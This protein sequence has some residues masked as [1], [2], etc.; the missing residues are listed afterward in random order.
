MSDLLKNFVEPPAINTPGYYWLINSE[1]SPDYLRKTVAEFAAKGAKVIYPHP[2]PVKFRA[3]I[4]STMAPDYLTEEYFQCYGIILDECRKHGLKL[5]LYDEGGWPSGGACGKVWASDPAKFTRQ[6]IVSNGPGKV[7]VEYE[8]I[9]PQRAPLPDMLHPDAVKKFIEFTHEEY[10]RRFPDDFGTVIKFA[11]MDE[12]GYIPGTLTRIP[13]C[14]DFAEEFTARKNYDILPYLPDILALHM[15]PA[16]VRARLDYYDVLSR[17]FTERFT[18]PLQK[19]CREHGLISGGHMDGEDEPARNV[20]QTYGQIMRTLRTLD[21]PGVDLIWRQ[22][23][24]GDRLHTFPKF[25]SSVAHQCGNQYVIGE[26]FSIYGAGLTFQQMRFLVAYVIVCGVNTLAA[27]SLPSSTRGQRIEGLRPFFGAVNPA[28]QYS[29]GFHKWASRL[30][31]L[32]AN[33]T[34]KVENALFY[35]TRSLQILPRLAGYASERQEHIAQRLREQQCDFDYIDDDVL[36]EAVIDPAGIRVGQAVYKRIILPPNALMSEAAQQRLEFLR[37]CGAEIIS[38]DE[39]YLVKPLLDIPQTNFN[40]ILRTHERSDGTL[41]H[42]ILNISQLPQNFGCAL[43]DKKTVIA[44]PETGCFQKLP[45]YNSRIWQHR[46][47]PGELVVLIS[48]PEAEADREM[49]RQPGNTVAELSGSWTLKKLRQYSVG[50]DD[51]VIEQFTDAPAVPAAPG[52]WSEFLGENFSGE[53]EYTL[54]FEFSGTGS[55]LDLGKVNYIAAATLN[56]IA[57][58]VRIA[59]P[60]CFD[61]TGILH[62][63]KNRLQI[64]VTNTLA[65][66]IAPDEIW[67]KWQQELTFVS[68]F[69][70]LSRWFEQESLPSGLFGPVTVKAPQM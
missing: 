62:P 17:L 57:L 60:Y 67:K 16:T 2:T 41:I 66:T 30:C 20:F 59:P 14:A 40:F 24:Q 29:D 25:A 53:A 45:E 38:S 63:G 6:F 21:M 42:F 52:S 18:Q 43:P 28:W 34:P 65:N 35:D 31:T 10:F 51:Y 37:S 33:S 64:R 69:E 19:W 12:P 9:D 58:G 56:G 54:D 5:C 68:P 32:A 11:F 70:R 55:F 8:S 13:W 49:P 50:S 47:A 23:W 61:V 44:D 3:Y 7:K 48:G 22:I 27:S 26:L 46:F 4:G 36:A 39:T 15:D 1:M